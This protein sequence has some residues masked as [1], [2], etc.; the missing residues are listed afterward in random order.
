MIIKRIYIAALLLLMALGTSVYGQERVPGDIIVMLQPE[1][2]IDKLTQEMQEKQPFLQLKSVKVLSK[3]LNI[4][5]LSIDVVREER[6]LEYLYSQTEVSIAQFNHIAQPRATTPNDTIYAAEQWNLNNTGQG[7]G[8]PGADIDAERAWDYTTGGVTTDG[9]TIVVAVIDQGMDLRH[10]DLDC[11]VNHN[12]VPDD[13]IDNDNNGYVDDYLGWN[14]SSED[15][16]LQPRDHGTHVAGIIGA[17]GNNITGLTGVNWNVKIMGV[18]VAQYTEAQVV[19]AYSYVYKQRLLYNQT[20]GVNGAFVVATNS[21]FGV[22]FGD[23]ANFPIWCAMYDSLGSVG[24]LNVGAT[25]NIGNDIDQSGDVPSLC[26]SDHLIMVTNTTKTDFHQPNSGYGLLSIDLGAPGSGI[27]S[28]L[29]GSVQYGR[30][31]GTSMAAPHVA[32]TIALM[33]AL[34]CN[35]LLSTYKNSPDSMSLEFKRVLLQGVDTIPTLVGKSTTGGRL[36]AYNAL[37]ILNNTY[38]IN[39]LQINDTIQNVSCAG[40]TDGEVNITLQGGVPPYEVS[41][42]T[43]DTALQLT[44]ITAGSY[45][46]EVVDSVGCERFKNIIVTEPATLLT[47]YTVT[48]SLDSMA[49]GQ[50]IA[51]AVGGVPPYVFDWDLPVQGDTLTDLMPGTYMVTVTDANGC[52]KVDE[53]IVFNDTSVSTTVSVPNEVATWNLYPNPVDDKLH[54]SWTNVACD[55]CE[56]ELLDVTGRVIQKQIIESASGNMQLDVS[57]L[58]KGM[59]LVRLADKGMPLFHRKLLKL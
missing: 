26:S 44:Q 10:I 42:S 38:C 13:G 34:A 57:G 59:Y 25:S 11:W 43:G 14:V 51:S 20:N 17:R 8:V 55:A 45:L 31:T 12:E 27:F 53:V 49:N 39:C 4:H 40:E 2:S 41:W 47:G 58:T 56:L 3:D 23:P 18:A 28:T 33:Y 15:D 5:L 7:S 29:P 50:I 22:D 52:E 9:D 48:R 30:R 35:D 6:L 16:T 36:N 32:G 21:S 19:A 46:I 1:A 24:I 37:R 54:L